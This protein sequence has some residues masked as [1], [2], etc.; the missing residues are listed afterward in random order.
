MPR[1]YNLRIP[2]E[3]DYLEAAGEAFYTFA[4]AEGVIAYLVNSLIPGYITLTRGRTAD[5][6]A[7]DLKLASA[8]KPNT[9]IDALAENFLVLV[10][11]RDGLLLSLPVT[12]KDNQQILSSLGDITSQNWD[13]DALWKFAEEAQDVALTAQKLTPTAKS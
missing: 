2:V 8:L 6:I 1:P 13:I 4:Y 9:D 3:E 7:R 10:S 11:K 12:A 5:E